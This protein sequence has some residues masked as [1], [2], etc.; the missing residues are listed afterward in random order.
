MLYSI[1]CSLA[2][3]SELSAP[4]LTIILLHRGHRRD[5]CEASPARNQCPVD[6]FLGLAMPGAGEGDKEDSLGLSSVATG[7]LPEQEGS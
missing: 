4:G 3:A 5:T 6:W 2:P 7:P 1:S